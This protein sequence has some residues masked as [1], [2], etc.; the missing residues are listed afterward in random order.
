MKYLTPKDIAADLGVKRDTVLTWIRSKELPASDIGNG[1]KRPTY[2]VSQENFDAF[3]KRR[4]VVET[5][6]DELAAMHAE[7]DVL[8]RKKPRA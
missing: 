4:E 2:R 6:P 1:G 3:M 8:E 5:T 7:I